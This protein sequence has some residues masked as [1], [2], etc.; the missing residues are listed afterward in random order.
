MADKIKIVLA[1]LLVIAGLAGF[2]YLA[3][4]PAILRVASVLA[5]FAA[6]S[7]VFWMTVPGKNFYVYAQESVAETKKVVWPTR[8]ETLQTTGIVFVFVLVMSLFLWAV[9]S[10]LLFIVRKF[11]GTGE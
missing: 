6:A 8:K 3:E 7:V 11:L 4:S 10:S 2:Y 1:A 9:D 5:G